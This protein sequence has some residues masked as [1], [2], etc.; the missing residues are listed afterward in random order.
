MLDIWRKKELLCPKNR[1]N[2]YIGQQFFCIWKI[3][4]FRLAKVPDLARK[5]R[6]F[7]AFYGMVG[8]GSTIF[9]HM[10][11]PWRHQ[12]IELKTYGQ[13]SKAAQRFPGVYPA[14]MEE[15]YYD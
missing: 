10:S 8:H 2:F 3:E 12:R 11:K 15:A 9:L 7:F 4:I 13:K 1:R 5:S 14:V 6:F